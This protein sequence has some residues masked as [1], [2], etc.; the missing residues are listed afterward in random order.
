MTPAV[1]QTAQPG[2]DAVWP[3]LQSPPGWWVI[4]FISDL[5]L[6]AAEPATFEVWRSY[7]EQT[8]ADAVFI[9]GDL[10]EVWVGD[11]A[12]LADPTGFEQRCAQ[13]LRQAAQR[14]KLFVMHGNRDFLLGAQF[15][16][17]CNTTLLADPTVLQ[18]GGQHW[19][20]SHGDELCL[21][22]IAYQAFRAQVRSRQWQ[23]DFLAMPLDERKAIA[24]DLRLRSE[25]RKKTN[26]TY[27][28]VDLPAAKDWLG[29]ARSRHMIHGHTHRPATQDLGDGQQ[30]F[31]L[32]DWD[33]AANPPRAEILRLSTAPA[34]QPASVN[35]ISPAHA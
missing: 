10:F 17:L 34:G 18:F 24:R 14:L 23:T 25:A 12:A 27:A 19:L 2:V 16:A 15:M 9:L 29:R 4:D 1:P 21:G 8:R 3:V 5:H 32:S 13:V 11:D 35:R 22:D 7:M 26:V 6:Q 31:V 33:A 30:R 28:D 20:L